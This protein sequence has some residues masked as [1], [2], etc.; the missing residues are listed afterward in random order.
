MT[1]LMKS[2]LISSINPPRALLAFSPPKQS[3]NSGTPRKYTEIT[4]DYP[5]AAAQAF[6]TLAAPFKFVYVSGEGA[7]TSPGLMTPMFGRIKGRAEAA[8]LALPMDKHYAGL[9]PYALRPGGVD[10]KFH[11]EIHP[12]I[13][14]AIG[15]SRRAA[16]VVLPLLRVTYKG[17]V[18]P[19]RELATV[20]TSLA[21]GDGEPLPQGKGVIDGRTVD[22]KGMRRLAGI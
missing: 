22:N 10:P 16:D 6:S 12:W 3:T 1:C 15:L 20:L 2:T 18:S 13:P 5:L 4:Y 7:T 9:K 14:Q 21:M 8:L 17:M 19:T 11:P